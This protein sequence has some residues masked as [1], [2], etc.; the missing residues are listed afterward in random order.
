M[1]RRAARRNAEQFAE[2]GEQL[3]HGTCPACARF[4]REYV[5]LWQ[6]LSA[7]DSLTSK[8]DELIRL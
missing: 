7:Y 3:L 8:G 6:P 4:V 2:T 1:L 5:N